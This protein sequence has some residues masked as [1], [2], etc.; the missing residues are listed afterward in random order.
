M[1]GQ[2]LMNKNEGGN[3]VKGS[4][5]FWNR[6]EIAVAAI[7]F[8]QVSEDAVVG[9]SQSGRRYGGAKLF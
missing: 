6:E 2:Q 9:I 1:P 5:K 3:G 7:C 8:L 4:R